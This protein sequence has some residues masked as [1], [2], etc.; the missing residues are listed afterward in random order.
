M[1]RCVPDENFYT[2]ERLSRVTN[3]EHIFWEYLHEQG[4][5]VE[6]VDDLAFNIRGTDF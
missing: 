3:A 4:I 1:S 2:E 6:Y 5:K